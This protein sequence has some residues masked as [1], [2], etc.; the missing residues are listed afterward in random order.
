MPLQEGDS[1]ARLL[2]KLFLPNVLFGQGKLENYVLYMLMRSQWVVK[3]SRTLDSFMR[4]PKLPPEKPS[5]PNQIPGTSAL[6]LK[7]DLGFGLRR[8]SLIRRDNIFDLKS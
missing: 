6:T 1:Q 5:E 2:Y 3:I 8:G 7:L 4:E